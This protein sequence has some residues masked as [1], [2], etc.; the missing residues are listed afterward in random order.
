M[1]CCALLQG[2]FPTQGS[3]PR[4]LHPLHPL[5]WEAG[6]LPPVPPGT[7][8][9][10]GVHKPHPQGGMS[11]ED[12]GRGWRLWPQAEERLDPPKLEEGAKDLPL[13]SLEGGGLLTPGFQT[14]A[15]GT[16]RE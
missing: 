12:R 13:E 16:E 1:S 4:L 7:L 2:I 11:R 3:N 14:L 5:H 6:S 15:S 9:S 10:V 8:N